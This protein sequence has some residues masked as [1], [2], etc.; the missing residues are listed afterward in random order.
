MERGP[1]WVRRGADQNVSWSSASRFTRPLTV[2]VGEPA[3]DEMAT[4][5]RTRSV[6]D[7]AS[8]PPPEKKLSSTVASPAP[9][10][11][12]SAAKEMKVVTRPGFEPRL[13]GTSTVAQGVRSP[14]CGAPLSA[15][16]TEIL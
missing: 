12:G 3:G 14:R 13:F 4:V 6:D 15:W 7:R 9:G 16:S 5:P 10:A 11:T 8:L 2:Q 1:A